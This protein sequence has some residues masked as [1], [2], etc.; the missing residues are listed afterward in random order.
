[1]LANRFLLVSIIHFKMIAEF[2]IHLDQHLIDVREDSSRRESEL[3][4]TVYLMFPGRK[5]W[6]LCSFI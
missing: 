1:M 5:H 4:A 3:V 2:T 6:G